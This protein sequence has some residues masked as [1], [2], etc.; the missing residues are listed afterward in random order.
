MF[1]PEK[2]NVLA[3]RLSQAYALSGQPPLV[4]KAYLA[5]MSKDEFEFGNKLGGKFSMRD[6]DD[7]AALM[8]GSLKGTCT[9]VWTGRPDDWTTG[10]TGRAGSSSGLECAHLSDI[11]YP[12]ARSR[13][14]PRARQTLSRRLA[15]RRPSSTMP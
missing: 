1:N 15:W 2:F 5:V 9:R 4:L 11:D 12:F 13:P 8:Q 6:Y 3:S 10:R 7:R 14:A